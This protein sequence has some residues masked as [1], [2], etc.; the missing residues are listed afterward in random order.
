MS[1]YKSPQKNGSD[2]LRRIIDRWKQTF[3]G[4][5]AL[6]LADVFKLTHEEVIKG[7]EV[8]ANANKIYLHRARLGQPTGFHEVKT[9]GEV[10]IKVPKNWE[11][12]DTFVAFPK[13]QILEAL[14]AK[15]GKDYG[16]FTN[17][18]HKGDSQIKHYYFKQDVLDNYLK[19]PAHYDIWDDVVCGHILTKDAYYFSLPEDKRDNEAFTQIRY[20]KRRLKNGSIAIAAI[21]KD[22]SDLPYKQQQYWASFEIDNPQFVEEDEEF[23]KYWRESFEALFLDHEDPLQ[24]IYQTV[25]NINELIGRKLFRNDSANPYLR[26]PVINTNSTYKNA[27]KELFKLFGPDSL[28]QDV[29]LDLLKNRLGVKEEKLKGDK[30]PYKGKWALFKMLVE[31]NSRASFE[32]LQRCR[33][34]RGEDAHKIIE[35]C[36]TN[37]DLTQKFRDD[38]LEILETF[39]RLEL[40]LKKILQ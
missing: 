20:G 2:T 17:R 3:T 37:I 18:L 29:L 24:G 30:Q 35:A 8:L 32:P 9:D 40:H 21:A 28:D 4:I 16:F 1:C 33:D 31:K 26:Y 27:H 38:C 7:L 12:V 5:T 34:A 36:L 13:R 10:M 11:M 19:Y 23:E 22:L 39:K 15:A 14:F 25:R 6:E